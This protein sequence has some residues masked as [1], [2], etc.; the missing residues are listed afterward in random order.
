MI[1]SDMAILP[2]IPVVVDSGNQKLLALVHDLETCHVVKF[3]SPKRTY[4]VRKPWIASTLAYDVDEVMYGDILVGGPTRM[5]RVGGY[6]AA[7]ARQ[8]IEKSLE[9]NSV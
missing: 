7:L 1:S 4:R 5:I 8:A 9:V 6:G 3:M 2:G